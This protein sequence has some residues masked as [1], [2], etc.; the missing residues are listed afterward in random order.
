MR[1]P[2][3]YLHRLPIALL[4]LLISLALTGIG[5]YFANQYIRDREFY[6]FN[7]SVRRVEE[8][9]QRRMET[10]I[11]LL[12][13]GKRFF[14]STEFVSRYEWHTFVEAAE[15]RRDYPGIQGIGYTEWL[16][17]NRVAQLEARIRGEG[18]PEFRVWPKGDRP[19]FTSIIYLEPFDWRN[20]RAFGYDMYSEPIRREAMYQAVI[21]GR[22]RMSSKVRLVQE[23]KEK[24][25]AGFLIYVPVFQQHW[26]A[27]MTPKQRLQDLQGFVYSPF[28][29]DDLF[30]GI[31]AQSP[32]EAINFE[33]YD[34]STIR[35]ASL[36]HDQDPQ[37]VS[38][39]RDP[40]A[41]RP[42][43]E[44]IVPMTIAGHRWTLYFSTLP[45]F[46]N[47]GE[48]LLPVLELLAGG[49]ISFLLFAI[50]WVL[51]SSQEHALELAKGMT[52]DL[53]RA[54]LAKD[55]FL[56]VISHELKTPLN[57]IMGFGS[58]LADE[59]PGPLNSEQQRYLCRM[60]QGS[61][62]MLVL[63]NNLLDFSQMV[64]GKFQVFQV[65][66]PIVPMVK[67]VVDKYRTSASDKGIQLETDV[68]ELMACI[69]ISHIAQVLGNLIDNAIKFTPQGGRILVKGYA[70]QEMIRIEV[71][72]TGVG[73]SPQDLSR[74]FKRFSQLDM[75]TTRKVGGVGLGLSISKEIVEAHGG[76]IGVE[77]EQGKGSTF[78][79]LIPKA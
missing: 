20:Q 10:Y 14:E 41:P 67:D 22:P 66:A 74:L 60:L 13:T 18:Y 39:F 37:V 29:A 55:E 35:E 33:I 64:A 75:S 53:R 8:A 49:L 32:Q 70:Q 61:D 9:I 28:R 52:A 51:A 71:T 62:R 17:Q 43:I 30:R 3:I 12:V 77:S 56:S 36:L 16:P 7:D 48:R 4:V 26:T 2:K 65:P 72:D 45:S 40:R 31:L 46:I 58:L 38:R 15:I 59:V 34:G 68:E 73:I 63:V 69:D 47:Q 57:F 54:D 5:W 11:T 44:R 19:Y 6:R 21:T 42:H 78:W 1:V 76:Q 25:Q 79:F 50:V 27:P 24:P 23:T